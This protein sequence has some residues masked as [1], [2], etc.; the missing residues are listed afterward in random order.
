MVSASQLQI[1][2]SPITSLISTV[3]TS[4][5]VKFDE[6]NYLVW[7]FQMELLLE[8]YGI[9]GF[10]DGSTHCPARFTHCPD[11]IGSSQDSDDYKIWKMHD[12]A[13]MQ[14]IT[15]T[16]SSPAISCAIGSTSAQ[17]LWTRLKEQFSTVTRTTQL[18]AEETMIEST[19]A[20]SFLTAMAADT[21]GS[22][23]SF[24]GNFGH[25]SPSY[26]HTGASSSYSN[27]YGGSQYKPFYNKNKNKGKFQYGQGGPK[28]GNNRSFYL[29]HVR[30]I[31]GNSP[32]QSL[33][34]TG[35][36]CQIF[37]H[38][39]NANITSNSGCMNAR[40]VNASVSPVESNL[41]Q[42]VWLTD[43]G[44]TNHMTADLNNLSLATPF[45][46]SEMIQTASGEGQSHRENIIQVFSIPPLNLHPMQTRSKNGI[47][48]KKALLTTIH[49][50][51]RVDL[52]T[53]EPAT[54]KSALKCK[55]WV[56]A[57]QEKLVALNTQS[58]WSLVPLPVQKNLVGCKW[59]FKIKKNADGSIGRYK[60]RLVAKGFNQEGGL[61]YGETFSPV[62]KPTTVRLVLAIAAHFGW[63]LRQL[64]VKNAFLHG[65][66]QEE[67]YMAQPPAWND[68]FTSFLPSLGFNTTYTNSS[69]FVKTNGSSVVVL[70]LYVDDIIVTGNASTMIDDAKYVKDLLTKTEM[71]DSKACVTPCLPYN[72]LVL[73]DGKPYN[74]PALYRSVVGALQYLTFTRPDIAF[75]VHQVCQFM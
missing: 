60:A 50:H 68:K 4:V 51:G 34:N 42:Q 28:F 11:E 24:K 41:S 71:L 58:T 72:R 66:L 9:M 53:V 43:S 47:F 63:N 21:G 54:Y 10:V 8:G 36:P 61:D 3:S 39:R 5:T 32:T 33:P 13:L 56:D 19:S 65:I 59:V 52:A 1:V 46:S 15:A 73:D 27:N 74:N 12:R 29:N 57:M 67:V 26:T 14:L 31:L 30:R 48:K 70:L 2:Q 75:A 22:P 20:P 35:N 18:L 38:F 62:V 25:Q 37:C 6:T 69:L 17:D 55:V 40:H 44:A 7:H 49:E 64:D 23:T 45:P 16:L